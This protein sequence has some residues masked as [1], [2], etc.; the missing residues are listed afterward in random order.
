MRLAFIGSRFSTV[1]APFS[2]V[3]RAARQPQNAAAPG[4]SRVDR[5]ECRL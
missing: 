4:F 3:C 1:F 5:R 2:T